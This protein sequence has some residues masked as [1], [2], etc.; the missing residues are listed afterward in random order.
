MRKVPLLGLGYSLGES[1]TWSKMSQHYDLVR[2]K[3]LRSETGS[4]PFPMSVSYR[5]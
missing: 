5:L 1:H 3:P 2:S 4:L